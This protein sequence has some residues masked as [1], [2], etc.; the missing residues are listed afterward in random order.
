MGFKLDISIINVP[1]GIASGNVIGKA[2]GSKN[3]P[4]KELH[5]FERNGKIDTI[6]EKGQ[7][8]ENCKNL[9]LGSSNS[10]TFVVQ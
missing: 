2:A 9:R 4:G 10:S 5:L 3:N 6:P 8:L 7:I 1:V